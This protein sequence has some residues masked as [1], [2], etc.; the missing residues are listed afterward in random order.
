VKPLASAELA[1]TGLSIGDAFGQMFFGNTNTMSMAIDLR[2]LPAPPRYLTDDSIMAIGIIETLTAR[3]EIDR[4]YLASRFA[5]NYQRNRRRGYD[6]S[7]RN[8]CFYT[9]S[10]AR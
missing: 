7:A 9:R 10:I 5:T 8:V 4:D 6:R 1:L 3:G 2:A